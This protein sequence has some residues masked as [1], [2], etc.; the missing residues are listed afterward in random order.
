MKERRQR[1]TEAADGVKF[2]KPIRS[3]DEQLTDILKVWKMK[4]KRWPNRMPPDT[5]DAAVWWM[6]MQEPRKT[7]EKATKIQ[8]PTKHGEPEK[9]RIEDNYAVRVCTNLRIYLHLPADK[10]RLIIAA[11]EDGIFWRG[12]DTETRHPQLGDR[13]LF[14]N[15][16][17]ETEHMRAIGV[18]EYRRQS[19]EKMRRAVGGLTGA[20]S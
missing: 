20:T 3:T 9:Y 12:E 6:G 5:H 18:S 7:W 1:P 15:I 16:I 19:R 11:H 4:G 10:Q 17:A 8:I 13:T 14:E 2:D